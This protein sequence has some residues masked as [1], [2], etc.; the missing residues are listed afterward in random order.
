MGV[1]VCDRNGAKGLQ[2]LRGDMKPAFTICLAAAITVAMAWPVLLAPGTMIFGHPLVGSHADPFVVMLQLS[3]ATPTIGPYTQPLTDLPAWLL[4]RVLH[5][6]AAWNLL[7]LSSFPLAAG[8]AYALARY[9]F[10]SH[11]G[12]VVAGLAFAFAPFHVAHAA[13]HAHVA[14]VHWLP[15]YLLALC[16][17]IDRPTPRRLAAL[18][19]AAAALT[20]SNFYAGLVGAIITP[21]ALAGYWWTSPH[22]ARHVAHLWKPAAVLAS[23]ALAGV[24]A[25]LIAVPQ[26]FSATSPYT[27]TPAE[28]AR[29]S[30]RWWAYLLPPVDHPWLGGLATSVFRRHRDAASTLVEQQLFVGYTLIVLAAVAVIVAICSWW[31]RPADR[32][33][34]AIAS[35]GLAAAVVSIGPASGSCTDNSWA[36]ACRIHDWLPMFRAYARFG[37]VVQLAVALAAAAAIARLGSSRRAALAAA[38]VVVLTMTEYGTLPPRAHE[39]LPSAA[40]RWLADEPN[41]GAILDCLPRA[42]SSP[43]AGWL[44]RR[45]VTSPPYPVASCDVPDLSS[46]LAAAGYA[47]VLVDPRDDEAF[48]SRHP[49][50][51]RVRQF[52][53]ASVYRVGIGPWSAGA[54]AP[55]SGFGP[56]S[57]D[58]D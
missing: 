22:T 41:A 35:I 33:L 48:A 45:T 9:L 2:A 8:A 38:A 53:A 56:F 23:T 54:S 20:L 25:A 12:A 15:L 32:T 55:A 13:Y 57:G 24:A 40:H 30:A 1:C 43:F 16:A 27:F 44:M 58:S 17:A 10:A 7:I 29:H 18:A 37:V 3:A 11:A 42:G 34:L 4:G 28:V 47:F 31:R 49:K 36:P 6:V 21:V 14:Q 26:V 39:V 52:H 50:L 46:R 51:T 5:P 19:L